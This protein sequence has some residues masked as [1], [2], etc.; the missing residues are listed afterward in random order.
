MEA[1]VR[2]CFFASRRFLSLAG[3]RAIMQTC[4]NE[5]KHWEGLRIRQVI[6]QRPTLSGA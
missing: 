3:S 1:T 4:L 5:K 6:R 2:V